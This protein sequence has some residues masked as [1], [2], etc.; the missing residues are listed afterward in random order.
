M[1]KDEKIPY[2]IEWWTKSFDLIVSTGIHSYDIKDIIANSGT[3]L[4]DGSQWLFFTL[5]R[6]DIPLLVFSAGIG[7]IIQEWI[8]QQCGEFKNIKI[9]SNFMQFSNVTSKVIGFQGSLIH[10]FNKNETVLID[11]EYERII[12]NRPNA[13]LLGDSIGD[14]DMAA[15]MP[16]LNN[17]L[18]IGFLNHNVKELLPKYMEIYDIVTI[19]DST[20]D[21]PNA[22]IRSII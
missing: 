1:T 6:C 19:N 22:I 20:V 2:M 17:I 5:E 15:G 8:T 18:K 13:I 4:K 12:E 7:N 9:I 3:H 14:V 10:V 16:A 11:T 21:V